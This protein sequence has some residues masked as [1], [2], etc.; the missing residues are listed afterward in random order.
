MSVSS[1]SAGRITPV[2]DVPNSDQFSQINFAAINNAGWMTGSVLSKSPYVRRNASGEVL[3][4]VGF[5]RS[6]TGEYTFFDDRSFLSFPDPNFASIQNTPRGINNNNI[7]AGQFRG[8]ER[9]YLG[10]QYYNV[11]PGAGDFFRLQDGHVVS[12]LGRNGYVNSLNDPGNSVGSTLVG[13]QEYATYGFAFLN[14]DTVIL[15]DPSHPRT[16]YKAL[17]INN[18]I[19]IVGFTTNF[20]PDNQGPIYRAF[21]YENG[22]Y[23]YIDYLGQRGDYTQFFAINSLVQVVGRHNFIPFVY[24]LSTSS[25]MDIPIPPGAT[26][27]AP[28]SINDVGQIILHSD[29][30]DFIYSLRDDASVPEPGSWLLMVTGFLG[31]GALS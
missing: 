24:N 17:G 31:L 9:V 4:R 2:P 28:I 11:Q 10:S 6:P 14:G 3:I 27:V 8:A 26:D 29:A 15:H 23:R 20:E 18:E 1:A 7:V 16:W 5:L 22:D 13:D 21:T 12:Q 30:G 25:F 19:V